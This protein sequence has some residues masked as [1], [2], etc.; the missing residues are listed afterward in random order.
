MTG[1][2]IARDRLDDSLKLR[3]LEILSANFRN[4]TAEQFAHDLSEKNWVILIRDD[5]HRLV[6]FSTLLLYD[7]VVDNRRIAVVYSGDTIIE[8]AAWGSA[9]LP[10]TWIESVWRLHRATHPE[11][12]LYWLLITSGFRTYRFL[13]V[14]W[15]EFFPAP[16]QSAPPATRHLLET[17]A[18]TRFGQSYDPVRGVVHLGMPLIADLLPIPSAKL[19]DPHVAFFAAKNPG[20]VDGDELVCIAELTPENLTPAGRR[21]VDAGAARKG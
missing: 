15:R 9:A 17:L 1:E 4:V 8:R 20:H 3:M 6:G 19:H 10:R 12:P 5:A 7:T 21:M 11:L 14:F 2:L 18:H 16:G 13:S